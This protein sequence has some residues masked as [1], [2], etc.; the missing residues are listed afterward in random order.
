MSYK[1][2]NLDVSD[3]LAKTSL[4]YVLDRTG[5]PE[6]IE[7]IRKAWKIESLVPSNKFQE[8]LD[9]YHI[10]L[11]MTNEASDYYSNDVDK[12]EI[13]ESRNISTTV[14]KLARVSKLA[15]FNIIDFEIELLMKKFGINSKYKNIIIKAIVSNEI[16]D[17]D[18]SETTIPADYDFMI[19][20]QELRFAVEKSYNGRG[21]I[22][23]DRDRTWYYMFN[24]GI[25]IKDIADKFD[26]NEE[27]VDSQIDRYR[28]F[29]RIGTSK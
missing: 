4:A 10:D 28:R 3:L 7:E 17:S 14:D 23:L 12:F 6:R 22:E 19:N 15:K 16:N 25:G 13:E 29:L 27:K 18:L 20:S 5:V 9:G 1:M 21:K 26:E 11:T 2:V 24:N 8:W